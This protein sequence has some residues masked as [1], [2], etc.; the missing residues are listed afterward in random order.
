MSLK[1]LECRVLIAAI[2]AYSLERVD[3]WDVGSRLSLVRR[4]NVDRI[5]DDNVSHVRLESKREVDSIVSGVF[6]QRRRSKKYGPKFW[7]EMLVQL[8]DAKLISLFVQHYI[9]ASNSGYMYL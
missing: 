3:V 7:V 4:C 2:I 5:F 8:R 6:D 1:L 9:Y